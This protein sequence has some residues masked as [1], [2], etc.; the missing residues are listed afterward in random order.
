[1]KHVKQMHKPLGT[2]AS[3]FIFDYLFIWKY[4]LLSIWE[5]LFV[6]LMLFPPVDNHNDVQMY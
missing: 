4:S 1:M 3:F 2:P 5:L 6:P